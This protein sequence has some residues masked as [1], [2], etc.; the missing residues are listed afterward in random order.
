MLSIRLKPVGKKHQRSFRIVVAKKRSKRTGK[1]IE[2]LGW[3]NPHFDKFEVKKERVDYW[4]S[5]GA[6]PTD[7]VFNILVSAQVVKGSKKAVHKKPKKE[8]MRESVQQPETTDTKQPAET[9]DSKG[10]QEEQAKVESQSAESTEQ[11]NTAPQI[12]KK[13]QEE[14]SQSE[15]SSS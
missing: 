3:Y 4:L 6:K 11:E 8:E 1:F 9:Q 10:A 14:E 5:V 15:K 7:T 12:E 2:D 13:K